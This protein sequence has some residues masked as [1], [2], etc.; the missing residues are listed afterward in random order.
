MM[1]IVIE[2]AMIVRCRAPLK[3]SKLFL[4][5]WAMTQVLLGRPSSPK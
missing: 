1:A 2:T 5:N 3:E 4:Q